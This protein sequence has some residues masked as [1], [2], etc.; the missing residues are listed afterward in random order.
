MLLLW[1][2]L[3]SSP[4]EFGDGMYQD[5][6]YYANY[7]KLASCV[8]KDRLSEGY[9][10]E[11]ACDFNFCLNNPRNEKAKII[12]VHLSPEDQSG[13][14]F[15]AIDHENKEIILS[16]RASTTWKDWETDL[17]FLFTEYKPIY[18]GVPNVR[19]CGDDCMIH[20]GFYKALPYITKE[21]LNPVED[22]YLKYPD[23]KIVT[24][25]HSLGGAFAT[26]IGIELKVR[27]YN[28]LIISYGMPQLFNE[29][30]RD[31][32]NEIFNIHETETMIRKG[33]T[34][35]SGLIRVVHK[36]D[37]VPQLPI[38]MVNAGAEFY[39]TK[40]DLPHEMKDVEFIGADTEDTGSL[41]NISS[42]EDPLHGHEHR[43]YFITINKCVD[44]ASPEELAY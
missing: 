29:D 35:K 30:M 39:I 5:L 13:T 12:K 25:G 3:A 23:Y 24:S 43:T 41:K 19:P 44:D 27:G 11:G 40:R 17:S 21:F 34:V 31:W 15:I 37:Y 26:I 6:I 7:A 14:G 38:R 16:F 28:P 22:L 8:H 36:G 9:L 20:S 32:V 4:S 42:I 10:H 18:E 1:C 2:A 33:E